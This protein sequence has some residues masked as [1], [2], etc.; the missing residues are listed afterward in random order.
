MPRA[1]RTVRKVPK[2]PYTGPQLNLNFHQQP[3]QIHRVFPA[4]PDQDAFDPNHY[5]EPD[6][7]GRRLYSGIPVDEVATS[8]V[9][10]RRYGPSKMH[11]YDP[12]Q[13]SRLPYGADRRPVR[14]L[15]PPTGRM[16]GARVDHG[17]QLKPYMHT[18]IIPTDYRLGNIGTQDFMD[19]QQGTN[20]QAICRV[21]AARAYNAAAKIE[22]A[23]LSQLDRRKLTSLRG[24]IGKLPEELKANI[25]ATSNL[26]GSFDEIGL[27]RL[28][29]VD[30]KKASR[31]KNTR[32]K[33]KKV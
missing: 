6:F 3:M 4:H 21:S 33:C 8:T 29:I 13:D 24:P 28:G 17:Q 1:K 25:L 9:D 20:N 31:V 12:C 26:G 32:R 7:F 19:D 11:G 2:R 14:L 15:A 18:A 30:Q 5:A 23:W 10:G 22:D 16:Y 27:A